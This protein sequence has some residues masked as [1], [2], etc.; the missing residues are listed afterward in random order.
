MV[1]SKTPDV[2]AYIAEAPAERREALTRLGALFTECLPQMSEGV[3]YG[4]PT[5]SEGGEVKAAFASQKGYIAFYAGEATIERHRDQLKG[6]SCGKSCIRYTRPERIDYAVV[7]SILGDI[8]AGRG[9][10]C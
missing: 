1:Q 4:M 7:K 9:R 5:W 8:A 3:D 6:I 2:A 10:S